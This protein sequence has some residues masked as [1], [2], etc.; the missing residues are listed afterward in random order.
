MTLDE[1]TG[2]RLERGT[3]ASLAALGLGIFVI[4]NDFT[5]LSVSVVQIESDLD[6]SLN[7]VQ[8]VINGYTVVFGVLIVTGGRLADLYGRRRMF[9]LGCAIFGAFSLLGGLAPSIEL[10]IAARAVMGIGGAL[11]W[12]AVIGL[13]YAILPEAKAGL[14]GGLVIGVAGLG[15]AV[16]PLIAGVLTDSLSWRWVFFVN[17]PAALIAIYVTRR[18]VAESARGDR[19]ALDYPGIAALSA[20]VIL[21]LVGLDV[22]T[23]VGF[24]DIAV[25]A[26]IVLGVALLV[27]FV[28]VER[29]QGEDALVPPRV[30][31]SRQ[32]S[33]AVV[34]IV[35]M[36]SL[37]FA[38]LL[39]V[40]QFTQK[41]LHWSA[42]EAGA[43]LLPLMVVFAVT[44][45]I[46]G[47]AY[48]R[49]GARAVIG[50]GAAC[51]TVGTLW[52]ALALGSGYAELVPGLVITGI[53][54][55]LYY[56]AITTAAVTTLDAADNSL[57]GGIVYMGNIAGGSLGLGLNTA[58]ALSA[59]SFA[60]GI[61]NAFFVDAALGVV[62]TVVAIAF[63][64][65]QGTTYHRRL[66]LHHRATG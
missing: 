9:I 35:L 14:A 30:T 22:G 52:L 66:H 63:I 3:L 11:M 1:T 5:A 4:A 55:G 59:S 46:A 23:D 58:I 53:G 44:S 49:V 36:S 16:G 26:M 51:L 56:S 57:A 50:A 60:D 31:S 13:V 54:V 43:G 39:Y 25:I 2:G 6:T 48:N 33:A 61:R 64:H 62:G 65:G 19:V 18:H 28:L 41:V 8:W 47:P 7:R 21:I 10:L 34:S 42:L 40:P 12:P 24:D 17:V 38:V 37:F 15:N 29:R 27:G 45:F 32:F 20:G